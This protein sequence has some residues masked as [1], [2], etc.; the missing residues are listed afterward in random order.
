MNKKWQIHYKIK[1]EYSESSS[2]KID[3]R[4]QRYI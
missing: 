1:R 2:V 3:I 4:G